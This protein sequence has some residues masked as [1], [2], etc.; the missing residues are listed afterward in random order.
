MFL[1]NMINISTSIKT[2]LS[3]Y[4]EKLSMDL[5]TIVANQSSYPPF[6]EK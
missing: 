3:N 4:T 5:T 1:H 6:T 2:T